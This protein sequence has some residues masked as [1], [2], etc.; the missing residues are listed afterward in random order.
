[1][2]EIPSTVANQY[3]PAIYA[4]GGAQVVAGTVYGD[5]IFGN[6]GSRNGASAE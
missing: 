5:V 6:A 2:G 4:S 3:I 1:M